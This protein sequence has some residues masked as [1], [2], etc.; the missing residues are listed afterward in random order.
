[1]ILENHCSSFRK[2]PQN[3]R[4]HRI[5]QN[6]EMHDKNF[7][8]DCSFVRFWRNKD[9]YESHKFSNSFRPR[10]I[11]IFRCCCCFSSFYCQLCA[12]RCL[13]FCYWECLWNRWYR[14]VNDRFSN[15][16]VDVIL[17][18][19]LYCSLPASFICLLLLYL[20]FSL[21]LSLAFFYSISIEMSNEKEQSILFYSSFGFW[22]PCLHSHSIKRNK[23][24]FFLWWSVRE[25]Q[26]LTKSNHHHAIQRTMS[27]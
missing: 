23:I 2:I 26:I 18:C 16:I 17:F 25:N 22:A 9:G 21:S 12:A 8:F 4:T 15:F 24:Y 19:Y 20:D 7:N 5:H 6:T 3:L 10:F 27:I 1:M 11:R 14:N 13:D